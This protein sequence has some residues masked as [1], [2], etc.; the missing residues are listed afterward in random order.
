MLFNKRVYEFFN[1]VKINKVIWISGLI[2]GIYIL[3]IVWRCQVLGQG[4]GL[5]KEFS[6]LVEEI[7]CGSLNKEK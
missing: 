2:L 7:D 6:G 5:V 4:L 1:I 3:V